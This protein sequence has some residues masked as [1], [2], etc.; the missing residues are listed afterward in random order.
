METLLLHICTLKVLL[1]FHHH[2]RVWWRQQHKAL[3]FNGSRR[4]IINPLRDLAKANPTG[5]A[6]PDE[7]EPVVQ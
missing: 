2:K 7:G 3:A 4:Q 6:A 5:T 1:H